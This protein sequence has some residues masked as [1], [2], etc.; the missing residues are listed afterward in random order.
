MLQHLN[1][2]ERAVAELTRILAPGGI[3]VTFDNDWDTLSISLADQELAARIGRFWRDS[4][5]SGRIG[6][7]L[8]RIFGECGLADIRTEPRTLTLTDLSVA[9]QVFDIHHLLDR[10]IQAGALETRQ[11]TMVRDELRMRAHEGTFIS[12]YT[13]YIVLGI[14]RK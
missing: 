14:K 3:L 5:A 2:P 11:A 4:F 10:M 7:D 8:P 9:E 13:G 12:G 1:E 6:L